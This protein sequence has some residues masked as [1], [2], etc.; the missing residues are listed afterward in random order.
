MK[1]NIKEKAN[2]KGDGLYQIGYEFLKKINDFAGK[3]FSMPSR[4]PS[5]APPSGG[6]SRDKTVKVGKHTHTQSTHKNTCDER[7]TAKR[8][9]NQGGENDKWK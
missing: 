5:P 1:E 7:Q 2:K 3:I 9:K 8:L 6:N 4:I